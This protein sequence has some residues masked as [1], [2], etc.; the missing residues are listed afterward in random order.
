MP[1]LIREPALEWAAGQ[2]MRVQLSPLT[3]PAGRVLGDFTSFALAIRAD[4]LW[5]RV[6]TAKTDADSADPLGDGWP[7][8]ASATGAVVSGVVTFDVTAPLETGVKR[9]ALDAW[10]TLSGGG[11]VQLVRATWL[12]AGARVVALGS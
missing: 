3:L 10:G 2:S 8:V 9:Y 11:S 6:G 1:P 5:P 7:L 4:P 12:T